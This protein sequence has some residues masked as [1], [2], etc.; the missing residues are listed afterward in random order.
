MPPAGTLPGVESGR[1]HV[2]RVPLLWGSSPFLSP[3]SVVTNRILQS[4]NLVWVPRADGTFLKAPPQELVLRGEVAKI[5]FV[6]GN[7]NFAKI[8]CFHI[9]WPIRPLQAIAMT[10]EHFSPY[11]ASTLRRWISR[12]DVTPPDHPYHRTDAQFEEYV[13]SNYFS[14]V[15]SDEFQKIIDQYPSGRLSTHSVVSR[16]T[17]MCSQDITQG[18]PYGTGTLNAVTPQFKR[19]AS[20]QGDITFQGPRRFFLEH[21]AQKQNAWSFGSTPF[22]IAI[23]LAVSYPHSSEQHH[24][25]HA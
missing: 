18:S 2:A 15:G 19:I 8:L 6:T 10:K 23:R 25:D 5:P 3:L 17:E 24:K 14:G 16:D 21:L 22:H 4:T 13:R 7:E 12:R 20:I 9:D 11:L 1:E